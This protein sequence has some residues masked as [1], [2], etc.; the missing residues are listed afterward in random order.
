MDV[1]RYL[2]GPWVWIVFA[3]V[4]VV[5]AIQF[6]APN[7]SYDEVD[8]STMSR[9][10]ADGDAKT[11]LFVDRDQVI[12][13]ELDNGKKVTSS[14]VMGQQAGLV[15]SANEGVKDGTIDDYNVKVAKPSFLGSLLVT[16]L[17]KP[18]A[19]QMSVDVNYVGYDIPNEF[20]VG[21]GLDYAERYRNLRC[22]GTLAPHVYS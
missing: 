12:Q 6:L 20:V 2:R 18:E 19:L 16:L 11:V 10:I 9:Y 5:L 7:G 15:R 14:W 22:I 1:K 4:A 8:T 21:Y 17:R 3:V 13:T